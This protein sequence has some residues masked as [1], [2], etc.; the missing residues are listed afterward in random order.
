MS[1]AA[2]NAGAISG[3]KAFCRAVTSMSLFKACMRALAIVALGAPTSA[4]ANK[5]WRCKLLSATVSGSSTVIRP[6]PAPASSGKTGAASPPA[7]TT[8]TD[9]AVSRC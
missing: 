3:A 7:P 8:N 2:I 6:T 9:A 1:W 5:V 4:S